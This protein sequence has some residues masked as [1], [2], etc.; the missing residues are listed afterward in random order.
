MKIPFPDKKYNI[1]YADPPWEVKRVRGIKNNTSSRS[2]VGY[3]ERM[4]LLPDKG[5]NPDFPTMSIK[6]IV[7]LPVKDLAEDNAVLYLWTINKYLEE[8]YSIARAWGF[9]PSC[10]LHWVK[11]PR[12]I[13]LA[14]AFAPNVEYL[15]YCRRGGLKTIKKLNTRWFLQP[16]I[17]RHSEK[18]KFFRELI[19]QVHGDLP[20]I[21][22]FSRHETSG[23]DVWGDEINKGIL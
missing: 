16:R 13:L 12:G 21:E 2:G 7:E 15:M 1:I 23:W 11:K 9:K 22:L 6:E 17:N 5:K 3:Y 10:L 19:T 8:T 18:P 4:Q 20:R 14:G